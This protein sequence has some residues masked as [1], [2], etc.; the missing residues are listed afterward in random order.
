MEEEKNLTVKEIF[1]KFEDVVFDSY[2]IHTSL[3][4]TG[5]FQ[6][7]SIGYWNTADAWG[8]FIRTRNEMYLAIRN[9]PARY[10]I[11]ANRDLH[12]Y[13]EEE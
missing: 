5:G 7:Y 12:I 2:Y 11:S 9:L 13:V 3:D 4:P 1:Y 6:T 8:A 10:E